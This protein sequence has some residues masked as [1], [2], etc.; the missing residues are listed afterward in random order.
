MNIVEQYSMDGVDVAGL[1]ENNAYLELEFFA[2]FK[3]I[4]LGLEISSTLSWIGYEGGEQGSQMEWTSLIDFDR[5][6]LGITY[7]FDDPIDDRRVTVAETNFSPD[8]D[9][10]FEDIVV[11]SDGNE[12]AEY[13]YL[14]AEIGH[15]VNDRIQ[16]AFRFGF[17]FD[18]EK[19][20]M[21]QTEV[22]NNYIDF[23]LTI[24]YNIHDALFASL[25]LVTIESDY[26]YGKANDARAILALTHTF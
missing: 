17:Y 3:H 4:L 19:I 24:S 11:T 22:E 16:L 12:G 1:P 9:G 23:D 8:T 21:D 5:F 7:G 26:D 2:E 13:G 14:F 6:T 15:S 25:S 10:N 20:P 18:D